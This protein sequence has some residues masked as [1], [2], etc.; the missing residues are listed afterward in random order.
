MGGDR[1]GRPARTDVP[2]A[3]RK[4][5]N[6]M[7]SYLIGMLAAALFT[8]QAAP[9][10]PTAPKKDTKPIAMTGC[11]SQ[12]ATTPGA[13]TFSD[14]KTGAKYRLSSVDTQKDAGKRGEISVGTGA[15]RVTIR[16]GLVPSPNVAAQAGAI[17]A[18]KLAIASQP[19]GANAGT[20]NVR[21][22]EFQ[23]TEIKT[24]KGSCP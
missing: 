24:I 17:D 4:E 12:D 2:R 7:S 21:L 11:L 13:F 16:G 23:A 9:A 14:A 19:G 20:G 18:S 15:L 1:N 10:R 22:P 5:G 6:V 3:H 8:M